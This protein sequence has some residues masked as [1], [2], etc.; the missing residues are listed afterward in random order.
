MCKYNT[1]W[2]NLYIPTIT[3]IQYKYINKVPIYISIDTRSRLNRGRV[4]IYTYL[5]LYIHVCICIYIQIYIHFWNLI[6]IYPTQNIHI[7][8]ENKY[9]RIYLNPN[10]L[11]QGADRTAG[12][13]HTHTYI[14]YICT[15]VYTYTHIWKYVYV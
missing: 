6:E 1:R 10:L 14:Q 2:H 9:I 7:I 4:R 8:N 11:I 5:Y 15:H 3:H 12:G 13:S